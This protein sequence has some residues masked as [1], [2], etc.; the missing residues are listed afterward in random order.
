MQIP[1]VLSHRHIKRC[2]NLV[3][4]NLNVEQIALD[5]EVINEFAFVGL[6]NRRPIELTAWLNTN[7]NHVLPLVSF[8]MEQG[9]I[10]LQEL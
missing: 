2:V 9:Q 8:H 3:R 1:V 7:R 5:A 6:W 10:T 4:L